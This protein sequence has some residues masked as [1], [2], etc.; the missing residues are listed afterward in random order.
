MGPLEDAHATIIGGSAVRLVSG[1]TIA[2][3]L[4]SIK[5]EG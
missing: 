3:W 1:Y 2:D 5:K 4:K